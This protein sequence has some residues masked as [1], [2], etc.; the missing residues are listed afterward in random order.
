MSF[1]HL[2]GA[3]VIPGSRVFSPESSDDPVPDLFGSNSIDNRVEHGRNKQIEISK[4]DMDNSWHVVAKAVGE[5]GKKGWDI[6]SQ[7]NTDMRSTCTKSFEASF[8]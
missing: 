6:E 4:H 7:N 5:E 2:P 8:T 3:T 1:G